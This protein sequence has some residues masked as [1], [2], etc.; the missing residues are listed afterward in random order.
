MSNINLS[1]Q[2]IILTRSNGDSIAINDL[3]PDSINVTRGGAKGAMITTAGAP[4]STLDYSENFATITFTIPSSTLESE[5]VSFVNEM[6]NEFLA[7]NKGTLRV[8]G[9]T[10]EFDGIFPEKILDITTGNQTID[11]TFYGNPNTT[12]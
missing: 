8:L 11:L 10:L 1:Q 3:I 6:Y 2:G 12:A 5:T 7:G 4:M 9:T